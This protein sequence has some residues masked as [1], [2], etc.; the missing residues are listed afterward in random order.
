MS[1]RFKLPG[2]LTAYRVVAVAADTANRFGLGTAQIKASQPLQ[3]LS[4]LPRFAI[5]GDEFMARVMLQNLT[6]KPGEV[7]LSAEASGLSLAEPGSKNIKLEA[8]QSLAAG[9][10]VKALETGRASMTF[11]AIMNDFS[12]AARYKLEVLPATQLETVAA[13][14]VLQ[15]QGGKAQRQLGIKPP[16]GVD[17]TRGGLKL[18]LAPSLSAQLARPSAM[19]LEYPWECLE[20]RISKGAA[21][22]FLLT[23]GQKLG[24]KA[25]DNAARDLAALAGQVEDF[26]HYS[27]GFTYW[28]GMRRANV[29]L[30]AYVLLASRQMESAGFRL[31]A[32]VKQKALKYLEQSL[33]AKRP[34]A[35]NLYGR[36]SEALTLWTLA[37]EDKPAM[38]GLD[39]ALR[40]ARGLPPFGLAALMQAGSPLN[41]HRLNE[42]LQKLLEG[43]AALS[44]EGLHFAAISPGGLKTVMG[45][46][47][48]GN[49]AALWA[50]SQH[51]PDYH[52][53]HKLAGWVSAELSSQ[54]N[55]ST[56]EAVFGIWGMHEYLKRQ[57]ESKG[58]EF[59]LKLAGK[60]LAEHGFN[61]QKDRALQ[62]H[63]PPEQI[64]QPGGGTLSIN[65]RGQ[66]SL[67]WSTRLA[68]ALMEPTAKAQNAGIGLTRAF[69]TV[70]GET[71]V[72]Q[73]GDEL[74]C[75]L[76]ILNPHTR[77]HV[78]VYAPYPAGMEPVGA[79]GGRPR[80]GEP[81]QG[82]AWQWQELR[83]SGLMLYA[84]RL[85]PGVYNY[86][87]RLRAVAPGS[88]IT[89]PARAEEMY[90]PE[91]F[92][93]TASQMLEIE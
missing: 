4:A 3:I 15:P 10:R 50:L 30:T 8:G 24:L 70:K 63:V 35:A 73:M 41:D 20:Q 82:D 27:G 68:Y 43:S 33:K 61:S 42:K 65:S 17:Q 51:M 93:S 56:Q 89:P 19:L 71:R 14:G 12:D 13:S 32:E 55:L 62:L 5:K 31:P 7:E 54:R 16:D 21:K 57:P 58:L 46:N 75:R 34:K 85:Q 26:Q 40:R 9:F 28:P 39:S 48:R 60:L 88:F 90:A 2:T 18:S 11:S 1:A 76:T 66:G 22:A 81:G 29:F 49:A 74:L 67:Y 23:Q 44:A 64:M 45:S 86:S 59:D 53:L 25:P 38:Q 91:V 80:G 52:G 79:A 69:Q 83:K 37:Q 78:A 92:G 87:F 6:D 72:W 77:H 84:E 36:L 47:L